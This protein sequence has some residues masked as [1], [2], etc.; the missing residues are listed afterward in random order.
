LLAYQTAW[1]RTYYP[2]EFVCSLFNAQPMGFYAPHVLVNDGK[3]HGVA[4]L[5]PDIN[6]SGANCA[7]EEAVGNGQLAIGE[8]AATYAPTHH[9]GQV[10]LTATPRGQ[11]PT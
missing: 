11:R 6:R 2:S 5:P 8:A 10:N 1:L 9:G 3:R 4:V 7:I